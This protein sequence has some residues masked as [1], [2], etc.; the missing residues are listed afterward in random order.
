MMGFDYHDLF[1]TV[2][3]PIEIDGQTGISWAIAAFLFLFLASALGYGVGID[4]H[5]QVENCPYF[6]AL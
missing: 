3:S 1:A 4:T 6:D 2:D 5:I